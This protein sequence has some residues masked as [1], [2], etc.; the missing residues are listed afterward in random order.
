M[1]TSQRHLQELRVLLCIP[2]HQVLLY[3]EHDLLLALSVCCFVWINFW[4]L[5]SESFPHLSLRDFKTDSDVFTIKPSLVSKVLTTLYLDLAL[6]LS[7]YCFLVLSVVGGGH[8]EGRTVADPGTGP[9]TGPA[10]RPLAPSPALGMSVPLTVPAA[11]AIFQGTAFRQ[12]CAV[13]TN[14]TD[15]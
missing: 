15:T 2:K 11:G 1:L 7:H 3:T 13:E 5:S 14:W 10:P 4:G 6:F 9:G 12:Q 8:R